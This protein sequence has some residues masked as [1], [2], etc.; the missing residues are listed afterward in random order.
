MKRH[1]RGTRVALLLLLTMLVVGVAALLWWNRHRGSRSAVTE[2]TENDHPTKAGHLRLPE[3]PKSSFLNTRAEA[4]YVGSEQCQTCHEDAHDTYRE[5][6]MGRALDVLD[7]DNEP[8]D[9]VFDHPKSGRRYRVYRQDG[10]MRHQESLLSNPDVVLADYAIR[11]VIGS[12]RHS[13]SYLLEIDGFMVESPVTW[14]TSSK[15]WGM[16]PGY[17]VPSHQGF[18][19]AVDAGCLFCHSGNSRALG[20]SFHRM[21]IH[22][23]WI[24]CERCHGPGSL[25][26]ERRSSE[27]DSS[28][29]GDGETDYTIVNPRHLDRKLSESIC[30]Q[31]HL[32]ATA[33]VMARGR[34]MTDF[35][36]GLPLDFFRSD[37]RLDEEASQ[38]TVVGHVEQLRFSRCYQQSELTCT[39]CHNPHGLPKKLERVHYYRNKCLSC[40]SEEKCSVDPDVRMRKSSDNNCMTCHMPTS[41]TEIPHLA[42]T[43]HRIGIHSDQPKDEPTRRAGDLIFLSNLSAHSALDRQRML[44]LAYMHAA[45]DEADANNALEFETRAFEQLLEAWNGGLRDIDTAATL[46]LLAGRGGQDVGEFVEYAMKQPDAP[47]IVRVNALLAATAWH[48][49]QGELAKAL[50]S[51]R[52]VVQLRRAS[53]DWKLLS[54]LEAQSGNRVAAAAAFEKAAQI[55]GLRPAQPQH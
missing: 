32:Q 41:D 4:R 24:G 47:G 17:D 45:E 16:S 28:A 5:T 27:A 8:P 1:G 26:L 35:R 48:A 30:S 42:F 51:A 23:T 36:P 22:E 44:G 25:H 49:E 46:A 13:R 40:H 19:R 20:G 37:Y 39:T 3:L 33:A 31:C 21:K 54:F 14:Y 9:V 53:G 55:D 12:G 10:Q 43:H 18:S 38:M 50:E 6:G 7:P 29:A 2:T 11:Y 52:E 34:S 15:A